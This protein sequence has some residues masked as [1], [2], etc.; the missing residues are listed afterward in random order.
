MS[1]NELGFAMA[2]KKQIQKEKTRG[3]FLII[4]AYAMA[5][6]AYYALLSQNLRN[7]DGNPT[8]A[9]FG[10]F[11]M[12]FKILGDYKPK[13]VAIT[14]DSPQKTFRYDFYQEYKANRKPMP[15]DLI[16]QIEVIKDLL[17]KI[18]FP[19]ILV[20][21][22]EADDIIG[23]LVH[24][25]RKLY[26]MILITGD[27][28]CFQLL[29]ENVIMLRGKKGV[30][31]F[32]EITPETVRKEWGVGIQQVI[33]FL[34]LTGDESDNIPGAKGI[35]PKTAAELLAKYGTLEN[36][37]AR[38]EE[39]KPSVREKLLESKDMV[40]LSKKLVTI[41]TDIPEILQ[42]TEKDFAVPD[43]LSSEVF[44]LFRKE[45]FQ[46]I[47]RDLLKESEKKSHQDQGELFVTSPETAHQ[48]NLSKFTKQNVE[49]HF[50]Y[51]ESDLERCFQELQNCE[52]L[53]IDVETSSLN[54]FHAK[55]VGIS[56]CP[57]KNKAYYISVIDGDSLFTGKGIPLPVVR[58]YFKK[59]LLHRNI[60]WIGQNIKFDYKVLY[61]KGIEISPVFFDT[62]I[63]SYL[64]NPA[65]RQHNL[66]DLAVEYLQY[67]T[68]KY[69]DITKE[70]KKQKTLD[71]VDPEK[72][73]IYS[74]EDA[75]ITF[76]LYEKLQKEIQEK[77]LRRI[78]QEVEVPLIEVL[79][80]MELHGVKIDVSYLRTLSSQYQEKINWLTEK[81]YEEA[82]VTF[83]INS[84]KELQSVLFEKMK[85]P[86]Q[87][88]TKTGFSTDHNV[89]E[90]LRNFHPVVEYLLQYRK[91]MKLKNT[92]ID[93]LPDLVEPVTGRIHT[94]FSQIS[95][96]TGRL[97][98]SNPNLQNIPV[99]DEEGKA[100]RK[101]FI[102]EEGWKLV[103]L[104]YS[105][106]ELRIL[107]HYSGDPN[108]IRAFFDGEDIHR[109]TATYLFGVSGEEVTPEMRMKAKTI[110]FSIIYGVTPYGLSQ[111]LGIEP[112]DARELIDRFLEK[113][114]GV[115][116]Y[117][118]QV[119]SFAEK[120]GYV[121][122]LLGRRREIPDIRSQNKR[123]K[124]AARRIAINTPIQGTSADIIKLA[125]IRIAGEI[126][127]RNLRSK[128]I[129]QV[130]DELVFEV[131]EEELEELVT[132]AKKEMENAIELKVPLKVDAGVAS[133]WADTRS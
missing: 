42:L 25:F 125:M 49:Y 95:T 94:H 69:E 111:S 86:I 71:Q 14:W 106:I 64:L 16:Y 27:K 34:A 51:T 132:I 4:D 12:L 3:D 7:Q 57:Q 50:L 33:D 48:T 116:E 2:G 99:K 63:A 22:Y 30:S 84:T 13:Y 68:I 75:D 91:L 59:Y 20:D 85:L 72:V 36:I 29:D 79:S 54:P 108:L 118:Q 114:P 121:E 83:N 32:V 129:L 24:K 119:V 122:T 113:F 80:G 67:E 18:G 26:K 45:G 47:Y 103:S 5:Y 46:Q 77:N 52:E 41:K 102:A 76:Q 8:W 55:L 124:E 115:N 104:D 88:K 21:G 128:M 131:P 127:K 126:Q 38:I 96:A 92:Y 130:H 35:G 70:G 65:I 1:Q 28:D 110:N 100:I 90:S 82:G 31:E 53:V 23:T 78:N 87:K 19:V 117:I 66:D 10:F 74:C 6:R 133:S 93:V 101:A 73:Y 123:I 58:E 112:S 107:A 17:K 98:S 120:N 44:S 15:E 56:L 11:R 39:I 37:Y 81:I 40:F 43:Y 61:V 105:Q 109:N 60:R 62:M 89:L 9:V 97:S